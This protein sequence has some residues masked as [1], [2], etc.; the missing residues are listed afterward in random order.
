MINNYISF[1]VLNFLF[2]F[3]LEQHEANQS[4]VAQQPLGSFF[5]VA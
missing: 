1:Y 5:Y 2:S 4:V 3:I